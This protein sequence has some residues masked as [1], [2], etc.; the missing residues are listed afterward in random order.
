METELRGDF[1]ASLAMPELYG[2]CV[3]QI[4]T[5]STEQLRYIRRRELAMKPYEIETHE[6]SQC[7]S[8]RYQSDWAPLRIIFGG[9]SLAL[10]ILIATGVWVYADRLPMGYSVPVVAILALGYFGLRYL[11]AGRR[12]VLTFDLESGPLRW[13]SRP[14]EFKTWEKSV[15]SILEF[16]R[17][18]G[19]YQSPVN[20]HLHL[21]P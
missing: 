17:S 19:L 16:A 1:V 14:G 8:V 13:T 20:V 9:L 21:R 12:H 18:K 15:G 6:I 7:R 3:G 2:K 4:V 10:A 5:V 11:L